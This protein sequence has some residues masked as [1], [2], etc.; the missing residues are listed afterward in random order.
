MMLQFHPKTN[1]PTS[2]FYDGHQSC[3]GSFPR[4]RSESCPPSS[5]QGL[6]FRAPFRQ[7][8]NILDW[9]FTVQ[10][11]CQLHLTAQTRMPFGRGQ[12]ERILEAAHNHSAGR[13]SR[14]RSFRSQ[15]F[16]EVT[17][18]VLRSGHCASGLLEAVSSLTPQQQVRRS[19]SIGTDEGVGA[20]LKLGRLEIGSAA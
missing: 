8:T 2:Y 4:R 11:R 13:Q 6:G 16:V 12:D 5:D 14:C 20:S 19:S 1:P 15:P 7:A 9:P 18:F 10:G 17:A 3:K